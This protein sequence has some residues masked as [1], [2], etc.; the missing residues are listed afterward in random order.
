MPTTA[1]IRVR[2]FDPHFAEQGFDSRPGRA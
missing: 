2:T 1:S